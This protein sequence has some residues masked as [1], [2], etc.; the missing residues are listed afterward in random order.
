M[1][2]TQRLTPAQIAARTLR[3]CKQYS[4]ITL[5]DLAL[6]EEYTGVKASNIIAEFDLSEALN[7]VEKHER[8]E[9]NDD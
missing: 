6:I 2:N 1:A 3:A 7:Y 9:N 5:L 8:W 4:E